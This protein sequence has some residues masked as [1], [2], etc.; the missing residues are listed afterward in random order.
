MTQTL[1]G[2]VALITAGTRSIGGAIATRLA[3]EGAAVAVTFG[4]NQ[5]AADAKV[6]ELKALGVNAEA[7]QIDAQDSDSHASLPSRIVE[8]FGRLDILVNNAGTFALA[9]IGQID[10]DTLDR[11]WRWNVKTP[12]VLA[13]AAAPLLSDEGRIIN[14][15]SINGHTAFAPGL[16]LYA[17]TKSAIQGLTRGWAR[18]L[19]ARKITVNNVEPGPVA[20]EMNPEDGEFADF[21][22]SLNPLGRYAQPNEIAALVGW[23]AS[24]A[25]AYVTG[26]NIPVDGGHTT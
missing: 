14:I 25:S 7:F 24:P 26:A 10:D 21:L 2:K 17:M 8:R 15:G 16:S 9:T 5:S 18:D 3:E 20:T 13:N 11:L 1:Q 4:G 23:L 19:A 6:T 22:R 12:I